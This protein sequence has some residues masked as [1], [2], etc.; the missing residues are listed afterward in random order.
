MALVARGS[1]DR[2]VP[3]AS[4]TRPPPVATPFWGFG[5]LTP[6]NRHDR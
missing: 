1:V 5:P 4:G 3:E 2:P 6:P